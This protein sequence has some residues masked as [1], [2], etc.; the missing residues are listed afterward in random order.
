MSLNFAPFH[1]VRFHPSKT[2]LTEALCPP[3]DV[4]PD[5]LARR[6]RRRSCSAIKLELPL[7][8]VRRHARARSQWLRWRAGGVLVQDEAPSYYV[9][10]QTFSFRGG[11]YTRIGLF[12]ALGLGAGTARRVLR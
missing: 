11:R 2:S 7:G 4:I 6:L 3:Y 5:A 8:G 9:V 1:G 12:G 10:E